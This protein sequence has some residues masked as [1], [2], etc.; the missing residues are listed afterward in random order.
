MW[1]MMCAAVAEAECETAFYKA[2]MVSQNHDVGQLAI[3]CCRSPAKKVT[4]SVS[5]LSVLHE[6][7]PYSY[8]TLKPYHSLPYHCI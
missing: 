5:A 1:V 7:T 8:L 4:A 2:L 3:D 6:L